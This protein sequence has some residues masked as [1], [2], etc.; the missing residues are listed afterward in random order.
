MLA[1]A[2]FGGDDVQ[3]MQLGFANGATEYFK[4][5]NIIEILEHD[6]DNSLAFC[7]CRFTG[8][9]IPF[10]HRVDGLPRLF[11][12][13]GSAVER[14]GYG[15][16]GITGLFS[17]VRESLVRIVCHRRLV[18]RLERFAQ[19]LAEVHGKVGEVFQHNDVILG[20]QF[21]DDAQL[22]F[23][24]A[25]PAGVVGIGI[26][27]GGDIAFA[28]VTFQLRFQLVATVVDRKSTRLNS[29][30]TDISRMPSSA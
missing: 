5:P 17:Y 12:N 19:V 28:E 14:L 11:G 6:F 30:H 9:P 16:K 13:V 10:Q 3:I 1:I 27:D 26:D 25:N 22:F 20:C 21:A 29:S 23:F 7:T 24:Q 4:G 15:G 18:R 8:I 2:A